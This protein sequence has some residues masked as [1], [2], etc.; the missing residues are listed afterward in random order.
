VRDHNRKFIKQVTDLAHRHGVKILLYGLWGYDVNGVENADFGGEMVKRPLTPCFPQTYQYNHEGPMA[1]FF[2]AGLRRTIRTFGI[3]GI[4]LDGFPTIGPL[5]DPLMDEGYVDEQGRRHGKWPIFAMRDWTRRMY[6]L[7][8]LTERR[9]GIVYI[10][11]SG[12]IPNMAVLSFADFACGGEAA[13]SQEL[14]KNCWPLD[15]YF[16]KAYQRPY[17]IGYHTLWYD[18]WNR[19]VKEN[20]ALAVTLLFGQF[21]NFYGGHIAPWSVNVSHYDKQPAPVMTL[22]DTFRLFRPAD[23]EWWPYWKSAEL[24]RVEPA[25]VKASFYLHRGRRALVVFSNIEPQPVTAHASLDLAGMG[26]SQPVSACDQILKQSVPME[27]GR[28]SLDILDERYRILLIETKAG[29]TH[30]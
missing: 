5:Y 21:L 15:E 2:M 14:L 22:V 17:G 29:E 13:P 1:D 26:F 19:P 9:D 10:H 27:N 18:W 25:Q 12:C 28:V 4:Y 30:E 23:A 8:H 24:L 3:D 16:V 11:T 20:Q 7:M 6:A